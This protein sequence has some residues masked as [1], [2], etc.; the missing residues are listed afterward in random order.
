[1]NDGFSITENP[2]KV[3]DKKRST[4]DLLWQW[5]QSV[6]ITPAKPKWPCLILRAHTSWVD[7][8]DGVLRIQPNVGDLKNFQPNPPV[9]VSRVG[10]VVFKQIK[11]KIKM[12]NIQINETCI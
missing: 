6:I 12:Q 4:W 8:I 5:I 7:R 3:A 9:W 2:E 11:N 10:R 1:M